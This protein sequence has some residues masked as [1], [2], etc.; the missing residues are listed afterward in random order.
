[1]Q[2]VAEQRM[3]LLALIHEVPLHERDA[4][5]KAMHVVDNDAMSPTEKVT[6]FESLVAIDEKYRAENYE[7]VKSFL[8]MAC[9]TTEKNLLIK[10]METI[11]AEQ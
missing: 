7:G 6:I 8:Q 10:E 1:M 3:R 9:L 4:V 2:E 11:V 5:I